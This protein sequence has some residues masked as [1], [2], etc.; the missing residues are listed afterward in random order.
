MKVFL[1]DGIG[2]PLVPNEPQIEPGL[3]NEELDIFSRH[4]TKVDRV[5]LPRL[6]AHRL[7]KR[8]ALWLEEPNVAVLCSDPADRRK[9]R[10]SG[11]G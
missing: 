6:V 2:R 8:E 10:L 11:S 7:A 3:G 9:L 1:T 4:P 5:T